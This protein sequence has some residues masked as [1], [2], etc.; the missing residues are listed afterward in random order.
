[1][2]GHMNG[3]GA[4]SV[5]SFLN[6]WAGKEVYYYRDNLAGGGYGYSKAFV[7][8]CKAKAA[9]Y[10]V[11]FTAEDLNWNHSVGLVDATFLPTAF[12]D[13]NG[14]NCHDGLARLIY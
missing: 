12:I 5:D 11:N 2:A 1:M 7:D 3:N 8:G 14:R 13:K 6:L 10:G 4:Y 9:A